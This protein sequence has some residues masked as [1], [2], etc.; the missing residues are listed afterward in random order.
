MMIIS[1]NISP[2]TPSPCRYHYTK[3][4]ETD[5]WTRDSPEEYFPPIALYQPTL[6]EFLEYH[7]FLTSPPPSPSTPGQ[8][9]LL[10]RGFRAAISR[11]DSVV[12]IWT[13]C[14]AA[15]L[16]HFKAMRFRFSLFGI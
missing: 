8:L 9:E 16:P 4:G 3:L 10:A 15:F 1:T 14:L 6:K 2:T 13:V 7:G 5:W 12:F 11:C